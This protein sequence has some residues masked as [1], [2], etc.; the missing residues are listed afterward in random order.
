MNVVF[1]APYAMETTLRFA[2]KTAELPGV[3]LGV[4]SQ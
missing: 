1:V 2:R 4:V 3:R